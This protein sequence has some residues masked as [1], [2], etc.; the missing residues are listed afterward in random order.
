MAGLYNLFGMILKWVYGVVSGLGVEPKSISYFAM[1]LMA[2]SILSKLISIPLTYKSTQQMKK[3]QELQPKLEAL[4]KKYGYDERILQ[5]KTMEFYK[6]NNASAAGCSSCLPLIIQFVIVIALFGVIREP[7]KY[8]F[9]TEAEFNAISRNFFWIS[10]LS[11]PDPFWFALPLI[12]GLSQIAIMKLNPTTAQ[13]GQS[14]AAGSMKM[15]MYTMP[16]MIFIMGMKWAS[17]LLLYW[18]FGNVIEIIMR[19]IMMLFG[20]KKVVEE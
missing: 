12:N 15:M 16:I 2:M 3:T 20:K 18:G 9:A 17:G 8:L 7:A 11:N 4:K 6:E 10:D 1:T 14:G 5:Q 13:T 19:L